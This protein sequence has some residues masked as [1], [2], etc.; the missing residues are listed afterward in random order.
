MLNDQTKKI[1]V[2][3]CTKY[4]LRKN[5]ISDKYY[6]GEKVQQVLHLVCILT[7]VS[8]CNY[9]KKKFYTHG[10]S[11]IHFRLF[12]KNDNGWSNIECLLC[13]VLVRKNFL[14]EDLYNFFFN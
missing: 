13:N 6:N 10:L 4:T 14:L 5:I 1:V 2:Y 3:A 12:S 11:V 7:F 9:S 8:L